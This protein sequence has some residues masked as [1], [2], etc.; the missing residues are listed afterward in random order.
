MN[1]FDS[2]APKSAIATLKAARSRHRYTQMAPLKWVLLTIEF[3]AKVEDQH[4]KRNC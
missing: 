2:V 4:D 1:A 3:K